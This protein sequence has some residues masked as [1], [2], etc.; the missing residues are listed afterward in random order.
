MNMSFKV[1]K[2]EQ[3]KGNPFHMIGKEW[4]LVTAKYEDKINTMT[5]SWGGLGIMWNK[6]VAFV[7]LRPSRYTKEFVDHGDTFTLSFYDSSYK[8]TLSYLGSVSGRHED[9]ITKSGLTLKIHEEAPYFEEANTVLVCKKLFNQAFKDNNFMDT[10]ILP[11]YYP[12]KDYHTLYIA[13]ITEVLIK[14]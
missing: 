7:V 13:E 5:A 9:K 4:M 8:K 3:L 6:D 12:A 14:E 2:A 11:D 10:S 1:I